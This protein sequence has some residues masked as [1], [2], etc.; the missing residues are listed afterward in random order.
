L[1]AAT[2]KGIPYA[3]SEATRPPADPILQYCMQILLFTGSLI[4]GQDGTANNNQDIFKPLF[5]WM[6]RG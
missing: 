3:R 1:R 6:D 5:V 2:A 4:Q